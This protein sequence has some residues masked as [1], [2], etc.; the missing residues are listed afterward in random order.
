MKGLLVPYD[1]NWPALFEEE[2]IRL[3]RALGSL[4]LRAAEEKR[5]DVISA[6]DLSTQNSVMEDT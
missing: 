4:A 1:P 3:R 5:S 6:A 2:A